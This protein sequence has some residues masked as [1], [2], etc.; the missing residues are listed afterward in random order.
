[1]KFKNVETYYLDGNPNGVRICRIE[2]SVVEAL[3]IPREA[4]KDAKTLANELPKHGIYF[5]IEDK[6]GIDLPKMYAGQTTNGIGRLYDHKANKEFW[7]LAVMFLSKDEHFRLDIISALESLAIKGIVES[8]RYDSDNKVDPKFKISIYQ[9]QVVENYFVDIKFLMAVLGWDIEKKRL[10]DTGEWQTKRRG[11]VAYGRYVEGRF[12]V[13]PGSRID[14][15]KSV[16]LGKYNEQR[17]ALLHSKQIIKDNQGR[18]ILKKIVSFKTPSGASD[19]VLGGSTNGWA[20]WCNANGKPLDI[21]RQGR[22]SQGA[23]INT[24]RPNPCTSSLNP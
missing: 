7:T 3:V 1:M 15:E 9:Q 14:M 13:L 2:G 10:N 12:D 5:L 6:E 21:L 20:E 23:S 24:S 18:F 4:V 16:N 22:L 11:I 17:K 8:E 19:F